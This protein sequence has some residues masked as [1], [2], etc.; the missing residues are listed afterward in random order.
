MKR[1][2]VVLSLL[3]MVTIFTSCNERE[4][5]KTIPNY[6]T[7]RIKDQAVINETVV[8]EKKLSKEKK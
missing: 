4:F 8:M 7:N 2:C 5:R 1:L 6:S 3:F